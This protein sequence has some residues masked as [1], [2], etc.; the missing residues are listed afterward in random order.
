MGSGSLN[1]RTY[2]AAVVGL[3]QIIRQKHPTTP[4]ALVSP[5]GYPPHETKPN[6]VGFTIGAQRAAMEEVHGRLVD[7]GDENLMYVNGLEVFDLD[8]IGRYA[9][10]Q[11]HPRRQ[12]HRGAGGQLR[13]CR[14]G[15]HA[16]TLGRRCELIVMR[17][18][19]LGTGKV[20]HGNYLPFLSSQPD[21]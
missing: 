14:H 18:G 15:A 2:P 21:G 5:I 12:R 3:V 7:L 8:L 20:A 19:V 1:A 6:A 9:E 17:I 4:L 16:R 13:P 11:C 10:D